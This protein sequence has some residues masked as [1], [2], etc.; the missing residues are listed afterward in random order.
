MEYF[1]KGDIVVL[2]EGVDN[3]H[4]HVMEIEAMDLD[5]HN[6]LYYTTWSIGDTQFKGIYY[7]K[8]MENIK[9]ARPRRINNLLNNI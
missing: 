5:S 6:Y 2:I 8:E 4:P 7:G 9:K 1:N 3:Y